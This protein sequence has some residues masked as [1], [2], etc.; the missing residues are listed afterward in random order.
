[1]ASAAHPG[2]PEPNPNQKAAGADSAQSAS[3]RSGAPPGEKPTPHPSTQFGGEILDKATL[4]ALNNADPSELIGPMPFEE[5]PKGTAYNSS[6]WLHS[7][8]HL[9]LL[10]VANSR[11]TRIANVG[12]DADEEVL[13]KQ[14]DR[15]WARLIPG[16][17]IVVIKAS[18]ARDLTA[19]PVTRYEGESSAWI[20]L[21]PLLGPRRLT[22]DRGFR[23]LFDI[24]YVPKTSRLWPAL[25]LDLSKPQDRRREPTRKK[26][27]HPEA[28]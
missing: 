24:L 20:N 12:R 28:K 27:E 21:F 1:M 23:E 25:F 8:A 18:P 15:V 26:N 22:G 17:M 10:A 4:D 3:A 11:L 2:E 5:A 14:V 13:A 9:E 7:P 16:T 19:I 6:G